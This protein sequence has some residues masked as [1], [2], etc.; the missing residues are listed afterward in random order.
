MTKKISFEDIRNVCRK[1]PNYHQTEEH[2]LK[3]VKKLK[4]PCSEEKKEKISET[5]KGHIVSEKV[6][7]VLTGQFSSVS[8]LG[9]ML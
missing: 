4:I 2:I 5:L 8:L 3:R 9:Q 7:N 1:E 6:R